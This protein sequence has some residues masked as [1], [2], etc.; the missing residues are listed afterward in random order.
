[1]DRLR[2]ILAGLCVLA[3]AGAAPEGRADDA[4]PGRPLDDITIQFGWLANVEY[5]GEFVAA[6]SGYFEKEG[7]HCT[8]VPGGPS[9]SVPVIVPVA[10]TGRVSSVVW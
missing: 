5:M 2:G 7:L 9:T 6:D 1:M 8:L 3:L 4:P 10:S